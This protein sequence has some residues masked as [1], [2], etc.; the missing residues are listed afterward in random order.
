[1]LR[2]RNRIVS[3]AH[4]TGFAEAGLPT[5]AHVEYY[6]E[7]AQG[8]AGLI[9]L[10]STPVHPTGASFARAIRPYS[11][12]ATSGLR[13]IADAVHGGGSAVVGQLWHCGRQGSSAVTG[14]PLWAPSAV[15]CP[16]SREVPK[17]MTLAEI[18]ELID[19]FSTAALEFEA[20]DFDGV[21]LAAGHG[22]LVHQFLSPLSN[23]RTD[24]YGGS[25]E[26]RSRFLEQILDGIR[27][28]CGRDF[29][30]GVRLSAD[31]LLPGGFGIEDAL[32]LVPRLIRY[33]L[34]FV[35]VSAGTHASVEQMVGDW[36]VPRGNLV[37]LAQTLRANIDQIPVVACGR[38]V[39]PEQA[40]AILRRG[41]AD[42]VGM[43]RALIA[44]PHW[45][46]KAA[47]NQPGSIRPC[48]ACNECESRLF[49]GQPIA[50]AVNPAL[51]EDAD[52]VPRARVPGT[53]IVVGG[54][55]AGMEAARIA[56]LR[57]HRVLLYEQ[58]DALGGQLRVIQALGT[59]TEFGRIQAF[60]ERE[61]ERLGVE[62]RRGRRADAEMLVGARPDA[63][64]LATG[65]IGEEPACAPGG[66]PKVTI[67][68]R[69][70]ARRDSLGS[71]VVVWDRE[72]S[73]D[74]L[75]AV[76]ESVLAEGR[77]VFV[78]TPSAAPGT[79]ISFISLTGI[80]RRLK[81]GHAR[82]LTQTDLRQIGNGFLEVEEMLTGQISRLHEIDTIV[83]VTRTRPETTLLDELTGKI[84]RLFA[85]GDC[86]APRGLEHAFRGGRAAGLTT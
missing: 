35:S 11:R 15:P 21:E 72:S 39:E 52:R 66:L 27:A 58:E 84:S 40:E 71:R 86:V 54:G 59:R 81:A 73:H 51:S 30:L 46:A 42:L 74:R 55:P 37:Y 5:R 29:V 53:V 1:L 44:D 4:V 65:S 80:L 69:L 85:A 2:L 34:D 26:R 83:M 48:I 17:A 19:A 20:A 62:V 67:P 79:D 61:L 76:A 68:E 70:Q 25:A 32:Q 78:V 43:T 33:D 10:E 64:I 6:G 12:G 18:R 16:V 49:K 82:L 63:V 57:G 50:C 41:E 77:E 45:G 23:F 24:S 3:T 38:I 14:M 47:R 60:L 56:A 75:L 36:S 13:Q 7:K 8:G 28:A 22:Y 31:E 9:V